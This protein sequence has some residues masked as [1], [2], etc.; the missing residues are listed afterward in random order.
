MDTTFMNSENSKTSHPHDLLLKLANKA[1]LR[2][3]E[4]SVLLSNCIIYCGWKKIKSLYKNN[5]FKISI[6]TWYDKF[7]W[8][9]ESYSTSDVQDN[10]KYIIKKHETLTNNPSIKI[11]I[12]KIKIESH[13]E[14][15]TGY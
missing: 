2:R 3:G 7:E 4:K 5:K 11:Y 1:D 9:G 14:I 12:N 15:K 10:F 13:F 8:P 6:S